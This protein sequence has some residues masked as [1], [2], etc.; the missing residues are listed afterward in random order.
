MSHRRNR[1]WSAQFAAKATIL[2][3]EVG[4]APEQSGGGDAESGCGTIDDAPGASTDH[5]AAGDPIIGTQPEP[6]GEVVLV[7]PPRHVEPDFADEG[8][9]DADVDAV[10]PRKIDAADPVQLSPQVEL[11]RVTARLPAAF[12]ARSRL[13]RRNG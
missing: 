10:D 11:G 6:R 5:F 8:L 1:L 3:A 4:L 12:D 2:G 13:A 7:L 9:R